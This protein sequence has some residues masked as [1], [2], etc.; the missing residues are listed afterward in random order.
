MI[1]QKMRTVG[2]SHALVFKNTLRLVSALLLLAI[3][4]SCAA[5]KGRPM[6]YPVH[7]TNARVVDLLPP[8]DM[9]SPIDALYMFTASFGTSS[10][11]M[12]AFIQA[13]EGGIF[14][15][16]LND[17]G[18]DMGTLTYTGN[19]LSLA[20]SVLPASLKAQ[21][22]VADI[23]F[24][25]YDA[26]AVAESLRRAGLDFTVTKDDGMELRRIMSGK[27][28]IEEISITSSSVSIINHLRGYEYHL[29]E[30]L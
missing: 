25:Y 12:Q 26:A 19:E 30:A 29:T 13:N 6:R 20:S 23:Q 9:V 7:V 24:A 15:N 18:S 5:I 2:K 4:V 14:I 8:E 10:F 16:L 27:K 11:Y 1:T 17:F 21:Y 28:C 22:I 3:F